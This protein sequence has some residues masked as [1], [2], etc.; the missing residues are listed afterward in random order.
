MATSKSSTPKVAYVYKESSPAG[1]GTWHPVAGMAS[2][3]IPY[4]WTADHDFAAPVTFADVVD[5]KAGVNNFQN[6]AARDAAIPSPTVGVVCFLRQDAS[7]NTINQ[8]QYYS[9]TAWV[10]YSDVQLVAKTTNY[11]IT[12]P[13]SG[14]A[15]TMNS[16][17]ANTITV[18]TNA[19]AA[20]PIGTVITVFQTGTGATSFLEASGVTILS[21]N[22]YKTMYAQYSAAQLLK[23]DTNVWI[24]AGDL[25]A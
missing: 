22:N 2:T 4:S 21:K 17:S 13:D 20:F 23:T 6:P 16:S 25:K 10:L 24:L 1:N 5:A 12:L 19:T 11:V 18:P 9:G 14:K 3:T 7:G 15:I 8:I